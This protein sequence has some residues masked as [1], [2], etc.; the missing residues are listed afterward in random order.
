MSQVLAAVSASLPLAAGWSLH[1]LRMRRRIEAARRDPLT[2]LIT[3]DAFT[4]RATR[5][6]TA[7]RSAVYLIDLDRF[8]QINDA[9]GHAAGDAVLRATGERLTAW[10]WLNDGEA[11][12]FGGDE[13][14][15]VTKVRSRAELVWMLE[16]L[17]RSLQ[18]PVHHGGR[19][20]AVGASTGAVPCEA[21]MGPA[22]L[23]ALLRRADEA[24]YAAKQNGGG[25]FLAEGLAPV[26]G[27]VNGRRAGR[28]GATEGAA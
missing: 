28:R 14:A 13:F 19:T 10:A 18:Q 8:K 21:S 26:G 15:A 20:L 11:A 2:G 4:E 1:S 22:G 23:S 27:A 16:E 5:A 24:M 9:Y 12:R 7:E 25:C 17:N 3:R 6:L